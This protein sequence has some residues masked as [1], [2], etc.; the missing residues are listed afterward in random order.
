MI[1]NRELT[2]RLIKEVA[3]FTK[4]CQVIQGMDFYR[5]PES[6]L[7][8]PRMIVDLIYYN[9][10]DYD[11]VNHF[12]KYNS[13]T[14]KLEMQFEKIPKVTYRFRV[15]N[16][17]KNKIDIYKILSDIHRYYSNPYQPK[18]NGD[19]QVINTGLIR[20][21]SSGINY[22][23]TLGYQFTMDFNASEVFTMSNDYATQFGVK[24]DTYYE[25]KKLD[26]IDID[27]KNK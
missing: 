13:Q 5:M 9:D 15:Y 2:G 12:E 18:L 8:F 22:D 7:K 11:Y 27:I 16:D 10:S 26:S 17:S 19:I 20:E 21:V 23:Y 1:D 3:Q 25:D 4:G 14:D 24:L 6:A